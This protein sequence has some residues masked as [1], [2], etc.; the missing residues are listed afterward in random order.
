MTQETTHQ[1]HHRVWQKVF[2]VSRDWRQGYPAMMRTDQEASRSQRLPTF[3]FLEVIEAAIEHG[4][5][6]TT[7]YDFKAHAKEIVDVLVFVSAFCQVNGIQPDFE[8]AVGYANG[9]GAKSDIYEKLMMAALEIRQGNIE[10]NVNH[11]LTLIIS[12]GQ[13]LPQ[14]W[15]PALYAQKVVAKNA[16]NRPRRLYADRGQAGERLSSEAVM[17]KSAH[18]EALLRKLR[19]HYGSPLQKWMSQSMDDLFENYHETDVCLKT[20]TDRIRQ[21]DALVTQYIFNQLIN[22][23]ILNLPQH[24]IDT[25]LRIAGAVP[26]ATS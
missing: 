11:L 1:T 3:I 23:H 2:E 17:A 25:K 18:T 4:Q 15:D 10:A 7:S 24:E 8:T 14:S 5:E 20:L 22:G 19:N 21:Q 16:A 13:H 9:Q 12:L 26:L 6:G